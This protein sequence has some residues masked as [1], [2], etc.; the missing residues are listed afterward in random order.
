MGI[1]PSTSSCAFLS[2]EVSDGSDAGREISA[3][4]P[5]GVTPTIM[6]ETKTNDDEDGDDTQDDPP[7]VLQEQWLTDVCGV[8]RRR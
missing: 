2:V 6:G 8:P 7:F 4:S 3:V 1:G 5:S